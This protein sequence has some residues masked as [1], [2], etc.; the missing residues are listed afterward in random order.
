M[1]SFLM[2]AQALGID[3]SLQAMTLSLLGMSLL[4][5][6]TSILLLMFLPPNDL[7][8]SR[9]VGSLMAIRILRCLSFLH[10]HSEL[11]CSWLE[12]TWGIPALPGARL[13]EQAL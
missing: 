9:E 13:Q 6:R 1:R 7:S 11:V 4:L 2:P 10:F 8:E 12:S 5:L 3:C